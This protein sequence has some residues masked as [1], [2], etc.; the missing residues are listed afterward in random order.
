[1]NGLER[2][3]E[4]FLATGNAKKRA[5]LER[6]LTGAPVRWRHPDEF[7]PI[8]APPETGETFA[9]N[10]D[11]K[12]L[13]YAEQ[14]GCACIADDSGLEVDALEGAPGVR[15]A[16]F[17]GEGATD[18]ANV[19]LLLE[20]LSSVPEARRT[21]RFRC[22]VS[23]AAPGAIRLRTNGQTEGRILEHPRGQNGFGYDPVFFSTELDQC[24]G[25]AEPGDKD[26]VSH[27]GRALR[28]LVEAL[29]Q[30]NWQP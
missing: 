19:E 16:R 26:Q 15:S 17:A 6:L 25:E 8:P 30:R 2:P 13:Y 23:L 1:M 7:P 27:R 18:Q 28:A 24:F 21:A 12:A 22:A 4:L 11:Q 10:A 14:T 9:E 20:R 5:E 29:Q 3:L